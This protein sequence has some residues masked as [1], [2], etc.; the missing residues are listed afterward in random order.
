MGKGIDYY[1]KIIELKYRIQE[2]KK[3]Y[4]LKQISLATYKE[5]LEI[6]LE[7]LKDNV[8]K[9]ESDE[10]AIMLTQ[11]ITNLKVISISLFCLFY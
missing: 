8:K 2:L 6:I 3:Q 11:I 4:E 9:V 7:E 10:F 1:K 5:Q